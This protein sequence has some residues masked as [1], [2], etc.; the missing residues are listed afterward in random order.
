MNNNSNSKVSPSPSLKKKKKKKNRNSIASSIGLS[1]PGSL[2]STSPSL[3][4][5]LNENKVDIVSNG[6][7]DEDDEKQHDSILDDSG[8]PVTPQKASS[9][10]THASDA[11]DTRRTSIASEELIVTPKN[12]NNKNDKSM[13]KG[14][15]SGEV[16]RTPQPKSEEKRDANITAEPESV[17]ET[18][19]PPSLK[20]IDNSNINTNP[21]PTLP[22][23]ADNIKRVSFQSSNDNDNS[24]NNVQNEQNIQ[25]SQSRSFLDD[26]ED[27]LTDVEDDTEEGIGEDSDEQPQSKKP[28]KSDSDTIHTG[29]YQRPTK[30]ELSTSSKES[31]RKH[32][33]SESSDSDSSDAVISALLKI[34]KEKKDKKGKK[35]SHRDKKKRKIL[36]LIEKLSVSSSSSESDSDSSDDSSSS[37]SSL[38]ADDVR[39]LLEM[40]K[41]K[42]HKQKKSKKSK[43]HDKTKELKRIYANLISDSDS[44]NSSDSDDDVKDR[45][46]KSS[47]HKSKKRSK[48][49]KKEEKE[50][51]KEKLLPEPPRSPKTK[52]SMTEM[53]QMTKHY[54]PSKRTRRDIILWHPSEEGA[55]RVGIDRHQRKWTQI[56]EDPQLQ[57]YLA[58]RTTVDLKDKFRNILAN[59]KRRKKN[60]LEL[61]RSVGFIYRM[62]S[63]GIIQRRHV[64][65]PENSWIDLPPASAY[66][67]SSDEEETG[68]EPIP[69]NPS[70]DEDPNSIILNVI[71]G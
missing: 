22:K 17:I 40:L 51:E 1:T 9:T 12:T 70:E 16:K 24:S 18:P 34:K 38:D 53:R 60:G 61:P 66:L 64:E 69:P 62:T 21:T 19:L 65:E 25:S 29:K 57:E 50:R 43:K 20:K 41:S 30:R 48:S 46:K 33:R 63:D 28:R 3:Q 68:K 49:G 56:K 26:A 35:E 8:I 4:S 15:V 32:K 59:I 52:Y 58:R 31:K 44:S 47:S 39:N 67:S 55:L 27:D 42:K 14:L 37:T 71:F 13:D 5:P 7:I 54:R 11:G 23:I 45:K 10:T 6:D 36:E 2:I